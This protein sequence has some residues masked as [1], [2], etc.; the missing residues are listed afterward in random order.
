MPRDK[1]QHTPA[2]SIVI[3]EGVTKWGCEREEER[4]EG[5]LMSHFV[6]Q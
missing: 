2:D 1:K 6:Y 4:Q 3:I 5:L